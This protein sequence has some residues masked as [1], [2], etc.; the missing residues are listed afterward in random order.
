MAG[1]DQTCIT[2]SGTIK[3]TRAIDSDS[4]ILEIEVGEREIERESLFKSPISTGSVLVLSFGKDSFLINR[5][6]HRRRLRRRNS[7]S[8]GD[9]LEDYRT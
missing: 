4:S 3:N 7:L 8:R 2:Y 1:E 9:K 6:V 5:C